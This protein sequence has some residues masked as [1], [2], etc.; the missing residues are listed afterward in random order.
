M[1]SR[2]SLKRLVKVTIIPEAPLHFGET[3]SASL[4]R[5]RFGRRRSAGLNG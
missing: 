3:I 5:Q 1:F 4:P 2:L